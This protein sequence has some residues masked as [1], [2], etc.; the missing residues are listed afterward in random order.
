MR[1]LS[2]FGGIEVVRVVLVLVQRVRTRG[3]SFPSPEL[4]G[5]CVC[6]TLGSRLEVAL[7]VCAVVLVGRV[8]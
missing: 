8:G 5:F 2:L 6:G 7:W 3:L 1:A 4:V